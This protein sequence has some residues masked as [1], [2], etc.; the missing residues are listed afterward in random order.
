MSEGRKRFHTDLSGLAVH[1]RMGCLTFYG[2]ANMAR[3][4][5]MI[6]DAEQ[7]V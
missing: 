6:W 4:E 2:R 5:R 3:R 1:F 7:E